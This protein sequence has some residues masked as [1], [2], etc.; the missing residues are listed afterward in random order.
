MGAACSRTWGSFCFPIIVK[1]VDQG[2][3]T[4]VGLW[5]VMETHLQVMLMGA[6]CSKWLLLSSRTKE[7]NTSRIS[8]APLSH[9]TLHNPVLVKSPVRAIADAML[10]HFTLGS[11]LWQN[12]HTGAAHFQRKVEWHSS[13]IGWVRDCSSATHPKS[14]SSDYEN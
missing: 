4:A 9:P 7:H 5:Q 8:S 13:E 2:R 11:P 12:T 3:S 14:A 10:T 1:G 6:A